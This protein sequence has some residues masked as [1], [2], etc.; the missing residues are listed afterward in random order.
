MHR[1]RSY[2]ALLVSCYHVLSTGDHLVRRHTVSSHAQFERPL[3][4]PG[5]SMAA[6]ALPGGL[7]VRHNTSEMRAPLMRKL[8]VS[9]DAEEQEQA[10]REEH[11]THVMHLMSGA[12]SRADDQLARVQ[13]R[14]ATSLVDRAGLL[15]T[16]T[17]GA[18]IEEAGL[19]Q[20]V[21]EKPLDLR[22]SHLRKWLKDAMTSMVVVSRTANW[23]HDS[24]LATEEKVEWLLG[25]GCSGG[26]APRAPDCNQVC[27]HHGFSCD[28][29]S[30]E[31]L[32]ES[33]QV[34]IAAKAAATKCALTVPIEWD[35]EWDGPWIDDALSCGF[36]TRRRKWKPT[37]AMQPHCGYHRLCP[38]K[39]Q[40]GLSLPSLQRKAMLQWHRKWD[41]T[42]DDHDAV[43]K[44]M[45][46]SIPR[47]WHFVLI[48]ERSQWINMTNP[49]ELIS[50][51]SQEY[52]SLDGYEQLLIEN[53]RY[54]LA[55]NKAESVHF[56]NDEACKYA[57]ERADPRLVPIFEK[58]GD[59][60]YKTDICRIAAL[61]NEGGYYFDDDMHSYADVTGAIHEDTRFATARGVSPDGKEFFQS[62]I[63]STA[64]H[65]I[66]K[67]NIEM[68][69]AARM[70]H[71]PAK[72]AGLL[73]PVTLKLAWDEVAANNT[74]LL[75]E[76]RYD[77]MNK[78]YESPPW[79]NGHLCD[80]VVVDRETKKM[81]FCSRI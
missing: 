72:Y 67:R 29:D 12:L 25:S 36:V 23:S 73:G 33:E 51:D 14:I 80:Y 8:L 26:A 4:A 69:V 61:Y 35:G 3:L 5:D 20:A 38:C 41:H 66:L 74:Q 6:S 37:C 50:P 31:P 17:D 62:F 15:D 13:R 78:T 63:A 77:P 24:T 22:L 76:I 65:P 68:L 75:Q 53:M 49:S 34:E 21:E 57:I 55:L 47:H 40:A 18:P 9:S 56:L 54:S 52:K 16:V 27:A 48:L 7:H 44:S 10:I 19:A 46:Q 32:T 58:E 39:A 81:L 64:C 42:C 28:L 60:R 59:I 45:N 30:L 70:P 2:Q 11:V 71:A 1:C 43:E 79:R